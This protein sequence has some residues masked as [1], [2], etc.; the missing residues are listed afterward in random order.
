[1]A[2]GQTVYNQAMIQPSASI[3]T[4]T[5]DA[6][7]RFKVRK[8]GM[9]AT[10]IAVELATAGTPGTLRVHLIGDEPGEWYDMPLTAGNRTSALFDEVDD[11]GTITASTNITIF[12]M[13]Q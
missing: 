10:A 5:F 6:A 4:W 2:G 3:G 11:G 7:G 1:M 9:P 13:P 8:G 12:V